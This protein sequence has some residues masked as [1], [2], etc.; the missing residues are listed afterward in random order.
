MSNFEEGH[1]FFPDMPAKLQEAEMATCQYTDHL[2]AAILLH[3]ASRNS[4]FSVETPSAAI[5]RGA[6]GRAGLPE[7]VHLR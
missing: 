2:P 3:L 5:Q 7:L 4:Q 6:A 1:E